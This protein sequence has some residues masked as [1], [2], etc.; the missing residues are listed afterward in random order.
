MTDVNA[1]S[2]QQADERRGGIGDNTRT[3]VW[4]VSDLRTPTLVFGAFLY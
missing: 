1:K 3:L 2:L 4:D